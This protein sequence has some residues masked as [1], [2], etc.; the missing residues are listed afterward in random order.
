[1]APSLQSCSQFVRKCDSHCSVEHILKTKR[2]LRSHC[3]PATNL[4]GIATPTAAWSTFS[5]RGVSLHVRDATS[6]ARS[7]LSPIYMP[8]STQAAG[9][10]GTACRN[11]DSLYPLFIGTGAGEASLCL[12][13]R[14]GNLLDG[15]RRMHQ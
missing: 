10:P 11:S 3:S 14:Y 12:F 2:R 13:V 6:Y 9:R 5:R 8:Y 7:L 1:M 15:A 4:Q